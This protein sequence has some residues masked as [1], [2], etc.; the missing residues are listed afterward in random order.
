[1]F[2]SQLYLYTP[3]NR[4]FSAID[5]LVNSYQVEE[6]VQVKAAQVEAGAVVQAELEAD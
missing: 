5:Q 1:M 3:R 4:I 2:P 6:A